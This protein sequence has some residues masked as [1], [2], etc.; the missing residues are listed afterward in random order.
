MPDAQIMQEDPGYD[1]LQHSTAETGCGM[2]LNPEQFPTYKSLFPVQTTQ[3]TSL[4]VSQLFRLPII[5][6]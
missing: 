6:G 3:T 1:L 2:N 5:M 4:L